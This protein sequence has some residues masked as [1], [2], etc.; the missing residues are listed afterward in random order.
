MDLLRFSTAGSVDDGKSTLIGRLLYDSKGVFEDQLEAAARSTVNRSAGPIDLS[1]LTDGLRAEREQG[2]TIDVAYRYFATPKRKF[3]IA[4]TPGHEQY[5]RNMATG[6]ST[7]N[8]AIVLIDARHGALV[9]SRR[10]TFIASMLGIPHLVVAVNKMDLVGYSQARY[11]EIHKDFQAFVDQLGFGDVAF[12]PLSALS[13]DN[14]VANTAAMPWYEGPSLLQHLETVD[15]SSDENRGALRFPVQLVL[16]PDLDF[17][18]FAGQIASGTVRVGD[19]VTALPAGTQSRVKRIHTH[20]GDLD[21]AAAPRSVTLLLEHEIDISRGDMIV[22]TANLP[23]IRRDFDARIVWMDGE[24]LDL[25]RP[26]LIKHTARTTRVRIHALQHRIDVN[27]LAEQPAET[28]RLNEI[29]RVH[30]KVAQPLFLDAY[31]EH[32][33]TGSFILI[34]PLTNATVA[35]GMVVADQPAEEPHLGVQRRIDRLA[36]E[37]HAHHR[38]ALLWLTGPRGVGRSSLARA[39]ET[40]LFHRGVGVVVLDDDAVR[41]LCRNAADALEAMRRVAEMARILVDA[42]HLV[43]ADLAAPTRVERELVRKTLG[44]H[45]FLEVELRAEGVVQD[46]YEPPVL[47]ELSVAPLDADVAES[48]AKVLTWLTDHGMFGVPRVVSPGAGI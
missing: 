44:A 10:H 33:R 30:L 9:Q 5:T 47:P 19:E 43:V 24:P 12:I 23:M 11:E 39:L 31:E 42:G 17:R 28:L 41:E 20:D 21:V 36:R 6:S 18:G 16:R 15:V 8:L 1:L 37:Q 26:Y 22:P 27:T 25:T 29:G 14:V 32:R 45:D 2:I 34:D 3:I 13:G 7:A 48:V 35:A 38:A 4:D 46:G 40:R